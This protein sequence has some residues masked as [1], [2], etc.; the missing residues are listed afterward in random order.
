MVGVTITPSAYYHGIASWHF[1]MGRSEERSWVGGK[2][3]VSQPADNSEA[4]SRSRKG[5]NL[6]SHFV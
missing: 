3:R 5:T 1:T 2:G 6:A 4:E